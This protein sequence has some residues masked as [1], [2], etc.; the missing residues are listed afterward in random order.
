MTRI[1]FY[2][3]APDKAAVACRLAT[4]A[5]QQKLRVLIVAPDE[6]VLGRVDRMLWV[7]PPIGFVPHCFAHASIAPETPVLLTRDDADPPHDDVLI[8]LGDER[9]KS[10]SRF[11]RLLEIVGEDEDDRR[12]ARERYKFYRDR[13]YEIQTHRLDAEGA[14]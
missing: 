9:P 11:Q 8:N 4:K 10:F 7:V 12:L 2:T 3:G 5:M 1:D 13:G 6:D 14:A